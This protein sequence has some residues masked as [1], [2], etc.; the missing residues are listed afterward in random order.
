MIG[1]ET[2]ASTLEDVGGG[3]FDYKEMLTWSTVKYHAYLR[4]M[5]RFNPTRGGEL[6]H[7]S[8]QTLERC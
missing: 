1:K 7:D 5:T 8:G 6:D 4:K 3:R 2:E